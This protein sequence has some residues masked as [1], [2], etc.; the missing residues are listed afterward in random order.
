MKTL[1]L[2]L[3]AS[4]SFAGISCTRKAEE[5]SR[6]SIQIP[7]QRASSKAGE[8]GALD[9]SL[10]HVVINVTGSDLAS[11]MV[12][13]WDGCHGCKDPKSP[14]AD[15]FA[16]PLEVKTT[17]SHFIQVLAVY[18][19]SDGN[20]QFYYNDVNATITSANNVVP[21][22]V[23]ALGTGSTVLSGQISGRY[24]TG[25]DS[26]PSGP[27]LIKFKPDNAPAM[28]IEENYMANGWFSFFGLTNVNFVYEL[29]NA[30]GTAPTVLFGGPKTLNSF[31]PS[32]QVMIGWLPTALRLNDPQSGT[33][34]SSEAQ[35]AIVGYFGGSAQTS[36]KRICF[37]DFSGPL[38]RMF[39]QATATTVTPGAPLTMSNTPVTDLGLAA[40][41][42][43]GSTTVK[44]YG[45]EGGTVANYTTCKT[46]RTKSTD[47]LSSFARNWD[48][49]GRESMSGFSFPF[50]WPNSSSTSAVEVYED[51]AGKHIRGKVMPGAQ[52]FLKKIKIYKKINAGFSNG[53]HDEFD[54]SIIAAGLTTYPK[55]PAAVV[56]ILA[57]GTFSSGGF[58]AT[59]AEVTAGVEV[60]MCMVGTGDVQLQAASF[61]N[62]WV[63]TNMSNG[64]YVMLN[65]SG[66]ARDTNNTY[67]FM[68]STFDPG[69]CIATTIGLYE[70]SSLIS[71]LDDVGLDIDLDGP[72]NAAI[73]AGTFY[74]ASNCATPITQIN[75]P[76]GYNQK[77]V[78]FKP[79]ATAVTNS[80]LANFTVTDPLDRGYVFTPSQ[81]KITI[82]A[83]PAISISSAA[84]VL[85][86][87][88]YPVNGSMT[89]GGGSYTT[90]SGKTVALTASNFQF[91]ATTNDCRAGTPTITNLTGITSNWSYFVKPVNLSASSLVSTID[92]IASNTLSPAIGDP[93]TEPTEAQKIKLTYAGAPSD[94]PRGQCVKFTASVINRN[95]YEVPSDSDRTIDLGLSPASLQVYGDGSCM[96]ASTNAIKIMR[97]ETSTTF[98]ARAHAS[99]L[100]FALASA[101]GL[102]LV[103]SSNAQISTI[104]VATPANT[105]DWIYFDAPKFRSL[106]VGSHIFTGPNGSIPIAVHV[107]PAA[108]EVNCEYYNGA[109][110]DPCNTTTQWTSSSNTIN[111]LSANSTANSNTAYRINYKYQMQYRSLEFKPKD[112]YRNIAGNYDFEVL[113]CHYEVTNAMSP[114]TTA[115]I[116]TIFNNLGGANKYVCLDSSVA[117]T[118]ATAAIGSDFTLTGNNAILGWIDYNNPLNDPTSTLT[119]TVD[120]NMISIPSTHAG[121]FYASA[122]KFQFPG[123]AYSTPGGSAI[124][125]TANPMP[126]TIKSSGNYFA[127]PAGLSTSAGIVAGINVNISSAAPDIHSTFDKFEIANSSGTL[128]TAAGIYGYGVGIE[129]NVFNSQ[130][131]IGVGS[132]PSPARGIYLEN[133]SSATSKVDHS[134]FSGDGLFIHASQQSHNM[135]VTNTDFIQS[136]SAPYPAVK[137][138]DS[139]GNYTFNSCSFV[140]DRVSQPALEY[141]TTGVGTTI[142]LAIESSRFVQSVS[143]SPLYF[144]AIGG[145]GTVNMNFTPR[146]VHF[147]YG[148]GTG[149]NPVNIDGTGTTLNVNFNGTGSDDSFAGI[150]LC[151]SSSQDW[152][153]TTLASYSGT[154]SPSY[155]AFANP[156][157]MGALHGTDASNWTCD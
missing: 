90:T 6:F 124:S 96:S 59:P 50:E 1:K 77:T 108:T 140:N 122:L 114:Q 125:A 117:I 142:N 154:A 84:K 155:T 22:T 94:I 52:A 48:G 97:G 126:G 5:Q 123:A 156:L 38:S 67:T 54:C 15:G 55:D 87:Q 112:F 83:A 58:V 25:A 62:S 103:D 78:Y 30:P 118:Y 74:T 68:S 9:L 147:I 151:K 145:G 65:F 137:L 135:A 39:V 127:M 100:N 26:G 11:P 130:F 29:Q 41:L 14:P 98:F 75:F 42:A 128:S 7:A 19:D 24:L 95:G 109:Q 69:A 61:L 23:K 60:A 16:M 121:I 92:G 99:V 113:P 76:V 86:D 35:M 106:A 10:M 37:D 40:V 79:S 70:Y 111:W 143:A 46:G 20:M 73:P 149:V 71:G 129:Y 18:V 53:G 144:T 104:S 150:R 138:G 4:I 31:Q 12:M 56:D 88:C 157:S 134:V 132:G 141:A 45:G 133:G 131:T 146:S 93:T 80:T 28:V 110:W 49:N 153:T 119:L 72:S 105:A 43:P 89:V 66:V 116:N 120:T 34:E 148:G 27:V 33:Y 51:A 81:N 57:D 2:L 82:L 115:Q 139:Y 136:G 3:I 101:G 44:Y 17:V 63:F 13:N 102:P 91:F 8:N 36:N 32:N 21:L 47:Y 107:T 152:I 64:P 85:R